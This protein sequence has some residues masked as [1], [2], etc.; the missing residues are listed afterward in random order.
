MVALL[1]GSRPHLL[2]SS[3]GSGPQKLAV[4]IAVVTH[5]NEHML[6]TGP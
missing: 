3:V 4:L 1:A 6:L 2:V 5:G